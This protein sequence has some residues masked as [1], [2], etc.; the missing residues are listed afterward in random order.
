MA[1]PPQGSRWSGVCGAPPGAEEWQ[2]PW[3]RASLW[4]PWSCGSSLGASGLVGFWP[5]HG[6]SS[7]SYPHHVWFPNERSGPRER[8]PWPSSGAGARPSVLQTFLEH[9]L[10]LQMPSP[11]HWGPRPLEA[12]RTGV[13]KAVC[14]GWLR[15]ELD[16]PLGEDA[17]TRSCAKDRWERRIGVVT[18][19]R[20]QNTL[21]CV[22]CPPPARVAPSRQKGRWGEGRPVRLEAH[23]KWL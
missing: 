3:E 22:P 1:V 10:R 15:T 9:P 18:G 20:G 4:L 14:W 2:G 11:L 5:Q 13:G 7:P 17:L 16:G 19:T 6:A 21:M 8:P 12:P 23:E